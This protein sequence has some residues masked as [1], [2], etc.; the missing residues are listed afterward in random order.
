M[1]G[2][3][4]NGPDCPLANDDVNDGDAPIG[5]DDKLPMFLASLLGIR[6]EI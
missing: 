2:E 1:N 5:G 3:T 6:P 4:P